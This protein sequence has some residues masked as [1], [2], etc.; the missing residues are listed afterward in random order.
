[1]WDAPFWLLLNYPQ[2]RTITHIFIAKRSLEPFGLFQMC[3]LF[4]SYTTSRPQGNEPFKRHGNGK[5]NESSHW[6]SRWLSHY[7]TPDLRRLIVCWCL[8]CVLYRQPMT[9]TITIAVMIII[10]TTIIIITIVAM[11]FENQNGYKNHYNNQ[12]YNLYFCNGYPMLAWLFLSSI[13]LVD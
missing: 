1:M 10:I 7:F 13:V 3:L 9:K 5:A 4:L 11:Y 8:W 2:T 6:L 12:H